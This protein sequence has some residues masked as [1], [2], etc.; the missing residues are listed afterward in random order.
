MP[1]PRRAHDPATLV[2][3]DLPATT[4]V[5]GKFPSLVAFLTARSYTDGP[6]RVPGKIWLEGNSLGFS[7][8]LIDV[9]NAVRCVVR[10]GTLDDVYAAAELL[11]GT[12]NA[13]WEVDQYQAERQAQKK[14]KK[15]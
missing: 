5:L 8:T 7:I 14:S 6:A 11:L 15:K 3:S 9:D 12:E 1:I 4:K 13:P 10:A 2:P